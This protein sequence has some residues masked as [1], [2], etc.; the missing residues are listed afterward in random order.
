MPKFAGYFMDPQFKN[1]FDMC[2]QNPQMLMQMIQ[3]DPRFMEVFTELTGINL[4][5]IGKGK[6]EAAEETRESIINRQAEEKKAAEAAEASKKVSDADA[7]KLEGNAFYKQK[8]F[9]NAI[10]SYSEAIAMAPKEMTYYTNLAAVYF[11][12]KDF[13]KVIETCDIVIAIS[14]EGNYDFVKL[15]KA[16][17]RKAGALFKKDMLEESIALYRATL[18]EHNDYNI[19]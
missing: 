5:D 18:L 19:K 3:M 4:N 11:E 15:G 17:A 7:K 16:M 12:M 2:M 9:P 10:A 14:K 8:D 1:M 6:A 13:D